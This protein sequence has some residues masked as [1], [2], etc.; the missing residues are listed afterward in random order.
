M[1]VNWTQAA[2][3]DVRR[4]HKFLHPL[5]PRAADEV[6][7]ELVLIGDSLGKF[8][9]RGARIEWQSLRAVRKLT[10]RSYQIRYEIRDGAVFI[11]R[12]FHARE[13]GAG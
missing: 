9:E 11:L 3:R 2:L 10:G 5:N 13:S 4:L 1:Q 12:V 8:P 6:A 7:D